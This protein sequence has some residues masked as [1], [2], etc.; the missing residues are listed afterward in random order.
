MAAIQTHGLS[1][2]YTA[3]GK[4][5]VHSLNPLHLEVEEKEIFGFLGRNGAGK[6]TTIKLLTGLIFPTSGTATLFGEDIH[7]PEAR[8]MVGYMPEQPYFYEYLTPRETLDFYGRLRGL[9]RA[10]R[11]QEWDYISGLLDLRDIA[12]R[13]IRGFS[14]GMRQRVGF[15]VALVG[16]PPLLILDEPMSGLDPLGRRMIREL[17]LELN[18]AGKT[19][20]FSS[21]VLG[22]V[23]EICGRVGILVSGNLAACGRIE[24]LVGSLPKS[25]ELEAAEVSPNVAAE[26]RQTALH[27]ESGDDGRCNLVVPDL[28][29]ANLAAKQLQASGA[30]LVSMHP[31]IESLEEFFTRIQEGAGVDI[32]R[33]DSIA[34][35]TS[36]AEE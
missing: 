12:D 24:N 18:A 4:A 3:I 36:K 25:V 32:P 16:N 35:L 7:A 33:E 23:E 31:V 13:R 34:A 8:R 15:A 20:F 30:T 11:F 22:D 26:L 10:E 27:F 29:A 5:P 9:S 1:K 6:T 14:K 17:M 2:T 21:H 19:I 28:R